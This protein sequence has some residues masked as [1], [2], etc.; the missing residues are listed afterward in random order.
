MTD[1]QLAEKH[2]AWEQEKGLLIQSHLA[3]G[4]GPL[5]SPVAEHKE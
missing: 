3:Q 5:E 2:Q 4:A 1:R